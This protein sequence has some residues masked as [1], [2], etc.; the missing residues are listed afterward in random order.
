MAALGEA[1]CGGQ[2]SSSGQAS[3]RA[4]ADFSLLNGCL[5]RPPPHYAGPGVGEECWCVTTGV[6]GFGGLMK[7]PLGV[8]GG[9]AQRRSSATLI[10]RSAY[11][12]A[13]DRIN[14][15]AL[16]RKRRFGNAI[17][18]VNV[19]GQGY[20]HSARCLLAF[21]TRSDHVA[22]APNHSALPHRAKTIE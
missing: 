22:V 12:D 6:C 15:L 13:W 9:A 21:E 5:K 1:D 7:C 19:T 16:R 20:R 18:E 4:T 8:L 17:G 14:P 10:R 2:A 3:S 11:P